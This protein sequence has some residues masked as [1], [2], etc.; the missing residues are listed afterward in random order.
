MLYSHDLTYDIYSK[1]D[2]LNDPRIIVFNSGIYLISSAHK[3][4]AINS[5]FARRLGWFLSNDESFAWFDSNG[6]LMVKSVYWKDG[7]IWVKPPR[8][9]TLGEGWLVLASKKGLEA[10]RKAIEHQK[11]QM[12]IERHSHGPKKYEGEWHLSRSL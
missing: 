8:F 10:R 6:E 1:G 3:W 4:I 2:G 11:I 5:N 9:D 12:W 7:W